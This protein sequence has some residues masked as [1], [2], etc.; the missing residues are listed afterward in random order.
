MDLKVVYWYWFILAAFFFVLEIF[1]PGAI[2]MWFGFGAIVSGLGLL[3]FPELSEAWQLMIFA[4]FSGASVLIWRKSKYFKEESVSSDRPELNNRLQSHMG[5]V[6]TL[7]DDIENGRASVKVG[8]GT[9]RVECDQ[10]L[11]AGAKVKVVGIE[12]IT[13]L[14]EPAEEMSD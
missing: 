2:F 7:A 13:F 11:K 3:L 4:L 6:Y 1:A 9:W 10:D 12:G 8:D 5:K 14:V